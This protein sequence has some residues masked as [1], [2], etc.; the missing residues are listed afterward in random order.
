MASPASWIRS[1]IGRKYLMAGTGIL[2][3]AF[4]IGHMVGN[5]Q[6][7]QGPEALNAYGEWLRSVGHGAGLW[8]ARVSLLAAVVVHILAAVSLARENLAARPV[9]YR[10]VVPDASTYASRTMLWSGPILALFVVYH[11]LHLTT[12]QAHPSFEHGDVYHNVVAGF[13]NPWTSGFYVLSML[14]LGL[15]LHHGIWSMTQS[16]GWSHPRIDAL[17]RQLA[18][19]ITVVVVVGNISIPV[20]VLLGWVR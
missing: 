1:S 19:G 6:V 17:R 10:Q 8:A 18:L 16:L 12:G 3:V 20:S 14:A 13:R 15:H 7:F 11:L 2:L 4:V 9:R 5:L